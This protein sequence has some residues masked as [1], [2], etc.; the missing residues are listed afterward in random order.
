MSSTLTYCKYSQ[1]H[2]APN[3]KE[4][5]NSIFEDFQSLFNDVID[6]ESTMDNSAA[7]NK[8]VVTVDVLDQLDRSKPRMIFTKIRKESS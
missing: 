4:I 2:D 6:D 3:T 7:E 1:I 5:A 8:E